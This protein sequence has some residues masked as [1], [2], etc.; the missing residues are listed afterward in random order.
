MQQ[1]VQRPS[2]SHWY[3]HGALHLD[4]LAHVLKEGHLPNLLVA[5]CEAQHH[6]AS[7]AGTTLVLIGLVAVYTMSQTSA[8]LQQHL[9]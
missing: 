6:A 8:P 5:K 2:V 7:A 3:H 4:H 1:V 9:L